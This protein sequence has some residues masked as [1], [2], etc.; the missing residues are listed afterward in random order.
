MNDTP[1]S[2]DVLR[3]AAQATGAGRLTNPDVTHTERTPA[4]GD[5]TTVEIKLADGRIE[6]M[7][8]DTQAC[9][10]AQASA[11][12][13]AADISGADRTDL[14]R[15]KDGIEA[16]LKGAAPPAPPFAGYE[17]LRAAAALPGRHACVLLPVEA[18]IKAMRNHDGEQGRLSGPRA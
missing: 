13:L 11:S 14:E 9:V 5:R 2:N 8:H 12:I 15:L 7:A 4:C 1:Y 3:L 6:S 17:T 16:M 10:L 18:A